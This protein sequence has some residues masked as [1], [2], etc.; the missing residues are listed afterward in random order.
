MTEDASQAVEW[1]RKAADQG[2]ARAQ[3]YL[4]IMY[5]KG[6]GMPAN[7]AEAVKWY[8]KAAEQGD[9]D[10]QFNLGSMYAN[11]E[12]VPEND[13]QAYAW[14]NIPAA[15]GDKNAKREKKVI[16]ESLTPE[17]RA[18]AQTFASK[19]WEAYVLPFRS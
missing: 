6:N 15:Q 12:G 9:I 17:A 19:Y 10:A 14:F 16:V 5:D 11:G 1:I 18:Q 7:N 2:F 4:G 3:C 13:V 8:R